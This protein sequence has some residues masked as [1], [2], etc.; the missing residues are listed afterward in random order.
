M[1]PVQ[2]YQ[3][4]TIMN[5]SCQC[6]HDFAVSLIY[7]TDYRK[8]PRPAFRSEMKTVAFRFGRSQLTLIKFRAFF[9]RAGPEFKMG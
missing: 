6:V 8:L 3:I 9:S 5:R 7:N 4:C 2:N 1:P